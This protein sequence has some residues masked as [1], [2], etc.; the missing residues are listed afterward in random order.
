VEQ[1]FTTLVR[2]IEASRQAL[3]PGVAGWQVDQVA[4]AMV[5]DAGYEEFPHGLGHQVGR[6]A[7]DGSALLGPLWEKYAA[8]AGR[9]IGENMVFTLEPRLPVPGH[10]IATIEE[11]VL[12]TANGAEFLSLA[13]DELWLVPA[14]GGRT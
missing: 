12:V 10:G 13:Q 7:H 5:T 3:Q 2:A 9:M 4:R 11:M 8:K 14:S 6:S 1:G